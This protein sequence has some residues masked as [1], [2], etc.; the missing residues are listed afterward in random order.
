MNVVHLRVV[1][2]DR[3][4]RSRQ[5]RRARIIGAAHE[6]VVRDGLQGL[7]MQAVADELDCAVGT[8]YRYFTSKADLEAGLESRAVAT[9]G[10]S[11]ANGMQRWD[12]QLANEH[13][14][15]DLVALVHLVAF[16]SFWSAA[17]VVLADECALVRQLLT[18]RAPGADH[19][20]QTRVTTAEV[21]GDLVSP[22]AALVTSAVGTGAL[23]PGDDQARAL[24]WLSSMNAVLDLD[25]LA[26]VD[27]HLFRVG[28]L[29]RLLTRSLLVGWGANPDMCEVADAHAERLAAAGPM[30]S[31]PDPGD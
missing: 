12:A 1:P 8:L 9:L 22:P 11:L 16:S 17:S 30:A 20:D 27:R 18:L 25:G 13:L 3:R 31:F 10:S 26:P 23:T 5:Q 24:V 15:D 28:H 6:V 29:M 2:D 14:P 19:S 4:Q 21:V 7:T